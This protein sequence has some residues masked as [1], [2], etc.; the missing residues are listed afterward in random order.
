MRIKRVYDDCAKVDG[1]SG[2]QQQVTVTGI[3]VDCGHFLPTWDALTIP[4]RLSS[5][6]DCVKC[7]LYHYYWYYWDWDTKEVIT[8]NFQK[9]AMLKSARENIEPNQCRFDSKG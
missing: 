2:Q 9:R 7:F 8:H 4:N 3:N 5:A 6:K 1:G